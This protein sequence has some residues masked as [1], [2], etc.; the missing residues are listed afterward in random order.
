M[1]L[2]FFCW[3]CFVLLCLFSVDL[4]LPFLCFALLCF[5]VLYFALLH[6]TLLSFAL[7]CFALLC[8]ALLL[9]WGCVKVG[10][11]WDIAWFLQPLLH[12]SNNCGLQFGSCPTG[13]AT[14]AF[15]TN[16]WAPIC[17]QSDSVQLLQQLQPFWSHCRLQSGFEL[18]SNWIQIGFKLDSNWIQADSIHCVQLLLPSYCNCGLQLGSCATCAFFATTATF[19]KPLEKIVWPQTTTTPILP[20]FMEWSPRMLQS[21]P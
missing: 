5:A 10:V 9:W 17:M 6:F 18:D 19:L 1:L 8:C 13:A 21:Y 7:L 2:H 3:C 11:H 4:P 12:F 14:A 16:V 20:T 15:F